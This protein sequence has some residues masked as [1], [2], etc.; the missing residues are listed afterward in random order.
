MLEKGDEPVPGYRLEA[1]L[2]RGQFG[3][4]WRATSPG[5]A[6]VAL[7]F[8]NLDERQGLKEYRAIRRFKTI[9]YPHLATVTALWLLDETGNVLNNVSFDYDGPQQSARDSLWP[10][11]HTEPDRTPHRLVVATLLCDKNLL[12]RLAECQAQGLDGIPLDELLR[13]MEEA[14]KAIDFLNTQCHDLGEGPVAIQHCDIKPA[15][16]MLTGG[17]VMICDFGVAAFLSNARVAATATSMAGSPAYMSPECTQ[18]KPSAASDQYSLAITY[19]ELRTGR[20][21]F[22][23][24]TWTDVIDAH[25]HGSLDLS[26][27][28]PS[29]RAV[30]RK[31]TSV[32]PNDR[33][34][35]AVGFVRA[36]RQ[37][38]EAGDGA[39]PAGTLWRRTA[40]AALCAIAVAAI[41]WG[42]LSA[43]R[44]ADHQESAGITAA[45]K[46]QV[47][48]RFQVV[49]PDAE[50]AVDGRSITADSNGYVS[51]TGATDSPLDIVVRK[52]PEYR[53]AR[54]QFTVAELASQ[55]HVVQLERDLEY[56]RQTAQRH[57]ARAFEII[58]SDEPQL[59]SLSRAAA[60]YQQALALDK[61]RY[62]VVPPFARS[63]NDAEQDY[64]FTIR[65]LAIHPEKPWL[66]GRLH[67][68]KLALW[69][70]ADLNAPPTVLHEN[71][72]HVC[73]VLTAGSY[74][75]SA[76]LTGE[77]KLTRLDDDG[78]PLETLDPP[79]VSGLEMAISPD[80]RW[81]LA[82]QYEGQVL[83]W[84]LDAS[85]NKHAPVL[86]GRHAQSVRGIVVTPDSQ[87]AIT[88]GGEDGLICRWSLNTPNPTATDALLSSQA[89][90]VTS[91]ALS[92]EG[93]W[94]AYG[95]EA[96]T[97]DE[98]PVSCFD[99]VQNTARVL[100]PGHTAPLSAL[101]YDGFRSQGSD[102]SQPVP[103]ASGSED[104]QIHV[105]SADG[106]QLLDSPHPTAIRSLTFCPVPG[107]L[108]SGGDDGSIG[109]WDLT[110]DHPKP[111]VLHGNAGRVVQ[112]LANSKWLIV[113]YFNGAILLWDIRRCMLVKR[114]AD[115]QGIEL[116]NPS[117][118]PGAIRT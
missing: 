96:K 64:R 60:E 115:Q 90:D 63:L 69:N 44:S 25:R 62:A 51:V 80:L 87:W 86:V 1:Y 23:S 36:L 47:T 33:Y 12:D 109:L 31:A 81:F 65:C 21:P 114:A 5:G 105:Y 55:A 15:N 118:S 99:L 94:V 32:D 8:L 97:A 3:E 110:Q 2:G 11:P 100:P 61:S 88:A 19:V 104:G 41:V 78:R 30:V 49:P 101:V 76:D 50:V 17:S 92:P 14:A 39:K 24:Q 59:P 27:L 71:A 103:L 29:E 70:L 82:G 52:P 53:E 6:Q 56:L 106:V 26:M 111:L 85:D 89:G 9:R 73:N 38:S 68:T 117:D 107:W 57:A 72:G 18:C 98:Y 40:L 34:P 22:R 116:T 7:K 79:D 93:R 42:S 108:I 77:I 37:A 54:K 83:A 4:V 43:W 28:V 10:S 16:I 13:Y 113:G 67:G 66:V 58:D 91:L 112:V 45:E 46:P 20:L 95:G 35:S 84:Q 75:A 74:A 102:P 48:V